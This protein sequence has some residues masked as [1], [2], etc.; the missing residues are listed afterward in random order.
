MRIFITARPGM[1][2]RDPLRPTERLT[3]AGVWREDSGAYR[4]LERAVDITIS[5]SG[6]SAK[7]KKPAAKSAAKEI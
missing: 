1:S 4:R 6:P 2:I 7:P 5:T 3:D